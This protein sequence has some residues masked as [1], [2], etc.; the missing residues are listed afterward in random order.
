MPSRFR[1]ATNTSRALVCAGGAG[2]LLEAATNLLLL[3]SVS[4]PFRLRR[5]NAALG[6]FVEEGSLRT[7]MMSCHPSPSKSPT[8]M[9]FSS[10]SPAGTLANT[11]RL[12]VSSRKVTQAGVGGGGPG[13]GVGSLQ[14]T[15]STGRFSGVGSSPLRVRIRSPRCSAATRNTGVICP[16]TLSPPNCQPSRR[17]AVYMAVSSPPFDWLFSPCSVRTARPSVSAPNLPS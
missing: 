3:A 9:S 1:S 8:A 2:S 6:P 4:T 5:S 11:R 16:L 13:V 14:L 10:G 15:R 17:R 7:T 12:A